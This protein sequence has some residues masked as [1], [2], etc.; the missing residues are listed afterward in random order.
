MFSRFRFGAFLAFAF[1]VSGIL[2]LNVYANHSWNGYHWARVANPFDLKIGDNV[3]SVWDSYLA[4]AS[5]DWSAAEVFNTAVVVSGKDPRRCK[6]TKGRVEV[7]NAKYGNNGWLGVA[8]VWVSGSHITQ[9]TVKVN[10][11]Y[12]STPY[13]SAS[14]WR[15]FVMCQEIGH[16]FG[17]D[18]QDE[19]FSNPNFGTCMDYTNNPAGPPSNE[20][21]NQHD[22]DQLAVIYEHFDSV[23]TV[24]SAIISSNSNGVSDIILDEPS[25][26]GR[27]IRRSSDKRASLYERDLGKGHKVFTFVIWADPEKIQNGI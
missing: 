18:H 12:F 7:C 4:V 1:L 20:H 25:Q 10:D 8:S 23:N 6:P 13:Y 21:P 11:T 14:A 24:F 27:V 17:L 16:T 9:G 26:W 2:A 19:D 5:G 22:Y 3:S 15:S